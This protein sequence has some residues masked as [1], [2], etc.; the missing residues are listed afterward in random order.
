MLST[1]T[2]RAAA[3]GPLSDEQIVARVRGGDAASFQVLMRRNNQRLSTWLVRIGINE[4][5]GRVRQRT[6]RPTDD[7]E[8]DT[9]EAPT[10]SPEDGARAS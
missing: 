2:A 9:M 7:V 5:L 3:T 4:A 6:R 8:V 1:Q 10:A